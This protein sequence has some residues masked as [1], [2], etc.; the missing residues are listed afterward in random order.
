MKRS[1]IISSL[2]LL[3]SE[4]GI[5]LAHPYP[6][7]PIR[8]IASQ[9]AGSSLDTIARIVTAK[10][11][12][13]LGQQLVVDNRGGAAGTIGLEIGA[14]DV[15]QLYAVQGLVP[16]GSASPEEFSK[17]VRGDFDRIAKLVKIAGIKPE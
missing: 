6:A 3:L 5:V 15:K 2:L 13:M 4:A 11:S 16:L 17:F 9:S 7:R 14:P 1:L 8:V 10:I 12:E